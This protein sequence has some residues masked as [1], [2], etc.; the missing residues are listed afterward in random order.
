MPPDVTLSDT[1][2]W[3][4]VIGATKYEVR[5]LDAIN[6]PLTPP[7]VIDNGLVT[8]IGLDQ[9]LAGQP[10]PAQY[11]LQVRPLPNTTW[12]QLV[13]NYVGIGNVQNL[14]LTP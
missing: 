4:P 8:E 2:Y 11:K 6:N 12:S 10:F 1:L 5:V 7:G 3:D 13:V 14:R 9:V